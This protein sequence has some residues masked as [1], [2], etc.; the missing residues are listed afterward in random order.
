MPMV[1][2]GGHSQI[3][4]VFEQQ[5]DFPGILRFLQQTAH[6]L[7][8]KAGKP[9][10]GL[11]LVPCFEPRRDENHRQFQIRA[12]NMALAH[13]RILKKVLV[14]HLAMWA[15]KPGQS[16]V[17]NE[18][19]QPKRFNENHLTRGPLLHTTIEKEPGWENGWLH[20]RA[21]RA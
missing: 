20:R 4:S 8:Q 3:R 17:L 9:D 1:F 12:A 11:L 16:K 21:W 10:F 18:D 5:Q 6:V 15:V 13:Y 7:T 14:K 19:D 2:Q